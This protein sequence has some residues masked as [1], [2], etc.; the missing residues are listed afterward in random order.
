MARPVSAES[1][2]DDKLRQLSGELRRSREVLYRAHR[3]LARKAAQSSALEEF[4]KKRNRNSRR[5]RVGTQ[6]SF[7]EHECGEKAV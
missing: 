3:G 6:G 7:A 4:L 2:R 1:Y 5:S